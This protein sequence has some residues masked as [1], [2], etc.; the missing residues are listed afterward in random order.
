M[1]VFCETPLKLI[2]K[3]QERQ[4]LDILTYSD[5]MNISRNISTNMHEALSCHLFPLPTDFEESHEAFSAVHVLTIS[6]EHFCFLL[7]T[8]IIL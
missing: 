3:E 7:T 4:E 1:E 6:K 2:L 5:I 8:K